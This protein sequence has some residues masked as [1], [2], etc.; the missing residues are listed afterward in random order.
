[1]FEG[2]STKEMC[3]KPRVDGDLEVTSIEKVLKLFYHFNG[4]N[5]LKYTL[6]ATFW[7]SLEASGLQNHHLES[8]YTFSDRYIIV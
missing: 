7:L 8:L 5:S 3:L 2:K 6:M 4:F 1:M